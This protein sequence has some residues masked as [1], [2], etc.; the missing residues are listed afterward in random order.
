MAVSY[1]Y[2]ICCTRTGH[3]SASHMR[4]LPAGYPGPGAYGLGQYPAGLQTPA[5]ATGQWPQLWPYPF[6]SYPPAAIGSMSGQHIGT[7]G[8]AYLPHGSGHA[9]GLGMHVPG[10]LQGPL[11]V[12]P[13]LQGETHLQTGLMASASASAG[14]ELVPPASAAPSTGPGPWLEPGHMPGPDQVSPW[15]SAAG[16]E[17]LA[18]AGAGLGTPMPQLKCPKPLGSSPHDEPHAHLRAQAAYVTE[19]PVA[20]R[21]V[22]MVSNLKVSARSCAFMR[23]YD[24]V[25]SCASIDIFRCAP[26]IAARSRAALTHASTRVPTHTYMYVYTRGRHATCTFVQ[27]DVAAR[28]QC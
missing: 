12:P 1:A 19:A 25:G 13:N 7:G 23:S 3:D 17:S 14:L 28:K 15:P 5:D 27:G 2:C 26:T 24:H 18:I 6:G 9:C 4:T 10:P 22:E 21:A 8:S 16:A 20:S 11:C